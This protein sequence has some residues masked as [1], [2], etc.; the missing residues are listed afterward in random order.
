MDERA[1]GPACTIAG[2][3]DH[4]VGDGA[5]P[6]GNEQLDRFIDTGR[7]DAVEKNDGHDFISRQGTLRGMIGKYAKDTVFT[8]MSQ[9]ADQM[10][11]AF[12]GNRQMEGVHDEG[13]DAAAE[14]G[15]IMSRHQ[16]E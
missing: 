8:E 13:G 15:G 6:L 9:F 7:C 12:K 2:K 14:A 3:V 4:H 1:G 10:M 11:Q 5:C 16:R